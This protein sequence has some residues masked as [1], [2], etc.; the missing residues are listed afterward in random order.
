[1]QYPINRAITRGPRTPRSLL[2]SA[3]VVTGLLVASESQA[4]SPAPTTPTPAQVPA[5]PDAA[6][7]A[8]ISADASGTD[9]AHAARSAVDAASAAVEATRNDPDASAAAY[10]RAVGA[11][12]AA[13]SQ[14]ENGATETAQA[15]A[16]DAIRQ[17]TRAREGVSPQLF[18]SQPATVGAAIDAPTRPFGTVPATPSVPGAS[19]GADRPFGT[20][21][22][23]PSVPAA[24]AGVDRPFGTEPRPVPATADQP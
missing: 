15:S 10:R 12:H 2:A 13:R 19:A 5:T 17:A 3:L 9:T 18:D 6:T 23:A 7:D 1:M 11:Y 22:A 14:L 16:E 4:Q 24:S 8:T 20:A 21:P